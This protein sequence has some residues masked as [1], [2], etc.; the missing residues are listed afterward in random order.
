[1]KWLAVVYTLFDLSL[2]YFPCIL[3]LHLWVHPQLKR[4]QKGQA[5]QLL[6]LWGQRSI[7]PAEKNKCYWA[8]RVC[9]RVC[10]CECVRLC[11]FEH[12]CVFL[13]YSANFPPSSVAL[14]G[15]PVPAIQTLPPPPPPVFVSSINWAWAWL[16]L[17]LAPCCSP[18]TLQSA[19]VNCSVVRRRQR[20]HKTALWFKSPTHHRSQHRGKYG[21]E[22]VMW[23]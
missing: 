4:K 20:A 16:W 9:M 12:F 6:S 14:D 17:W 10:V 11:V 19:P 15:S 13:P 1:M 18:L 2:E 22:V 21:N 8:A 23:D 3:R 7:N 5:P